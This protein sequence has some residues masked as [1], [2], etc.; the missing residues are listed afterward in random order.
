[1]ADKPSKIDPKLVDELREGQDPQKVLSFE[2]R[3][4]S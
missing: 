3:L 4:R 2:G 1:M